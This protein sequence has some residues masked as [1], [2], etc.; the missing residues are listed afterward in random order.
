MMRS[1]YA[2]VSGIR[3]HQIKMDVIGNN[4]SNVNT[5]GFKAGRACF[6]DLFNQTMR[7]ATSPSSGL[8]GMNAMQVG[9]GVSTATVDRAFTTGA[10]MTTGRMLDL[11]LQGDGLFVCK[12]GSD[13]FYTRSGNLYLDEDG[14][15]LTA[16]GQYLQGIMIDSEYSQRE[17]TY[18]IE[19]VSHTVTE[20]TIG[21]EVPEPITRYVFESDKEDIE[22]GDLSDPENEERFELI[23]DIV[24]PLDFTNFSI[25]RTGL[26]TGLSPGGE[27][28]DIAVLPLAAFANYEGLTLEG[29]NLYTQSSNSGVPLFKQAGQGGAVGDMRAGALEMSNVDLSKEFTDMIVTQ[30]GF[31]ANSRIITVSDTMLE[32][33]INLKR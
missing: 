19:G 29:D 25:D 8:G 31:Q 18:E 16:S 28:V 24:F 17:V 10:T 7:G 32:E 33:L 14:F 15:L 30:R 6:V 3:A 12:R 20:T 2:G 5:Q 22:W 21:L 26:V 11:A 9:L 1:L 23:G 4:I 27:L 13:L